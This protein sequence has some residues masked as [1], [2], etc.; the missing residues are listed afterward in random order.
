M[1][2][3]NNVFAPILEKLGIGK[4]QPTQTTR[5]ER[6]VKNF[7]DGE[8][9]L[10]MDWTEGSKKQQTW[11]NKL[12][13]E[14]MQEAKEDIDYAVKENAITQEQA[15]MIKKEINKYIEL[16]DDANWW[17]DNQDMNVRKKM[18]EITSAS[19]EL[20]KIIKRVAF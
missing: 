18:I 7:I 2:G 14:F 9:E 11:A 8:E 13:K 10:E 3:K 19:E 5:I 1:L 16:Q 15:D 20:E 6:P 12:V 17:I 4:K